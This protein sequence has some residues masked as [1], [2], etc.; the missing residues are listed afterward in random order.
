MKKISENL[1]HCLNVEERV[2]LTLAALS[3]SDD[4]E[5]ARL[6]RTCPKSEYTMLDYEY[7]NKLE[8]L[9][10]IAAQFL[11][12][13]HFNRSQILIC[14]TCL[15]AFSIL[16]PVFSDK[17]IERQY[18]K[19]CISKKGHISHIKGLFRGLHEFCN[20]VSL[21]EVHFLAWL[22]INPEV[23]RDFI[24]DELFFDVGPDVGFTESA[25]LWYPILPI[26]YKQ[27][28]RLSF[29]I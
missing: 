4:E 27:F 9:P 17:D 24:N 28:H 6:R 12:I 20:E 18:E 15:I 11:E 21:N 16:D 7:T 23:M 8:T 14:T 3:V 1:Y 25:N 29:V 2:S 19:L 22:K 26:H 10:W 13:Y 5:I